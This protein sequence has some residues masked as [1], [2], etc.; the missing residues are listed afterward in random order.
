MMQITPIVKNL[1]II[2]AIVFFGVQ[3]ALQPFGI[4]DYFPLRQIG[5]GFN[6]YQ[7]VSHMFMH[8]NIQHLFFN[9]LTL[10]FLGPVTEYGLG[11]KKFL[12]LYIV[13]GLVGGI[14]H[15]LMESNPAWGASGAINGVVVAFATMYPN[16]E[17]MVF[18]F[19][20]QIKAKYLVAAFVG[21]DFFYGV[22]NYYSGVAHFAHLG[23]AATGFIMI[24]IWKMANMR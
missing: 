23:G 24:H 11:S 20:F 16:R 8:G 14:V 7:L 2:N 22:T 3:Y 9:M 1:I 6:P 21:I 5:Q 10:F 19:P 17:L 4:L 12:Q 15:L 18:P 13:A